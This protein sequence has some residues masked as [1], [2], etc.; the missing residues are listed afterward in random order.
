MQIAF[1]VNGSYLFLLNWHRP[2]QCL[3]NSNTSEYKKNRLF[4]RIFQLILF[5]GLLPKTLLRNFSQYLDFQFSNLDALM[6]CHLLKN[7]LWNKLYLVFL[8]FNESLLV[9]N[10]WLLLSCY[11]RVSEWTT[12]YLVWL[13][14]LLDFFQFYSYGKKK[15]TC[16][17]L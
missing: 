2:M 6:V 9:L 16:I 15:S 3:H 5:K 10:H 14:P 7:F 4:L 12:N 13:K 17:L 8:I 11:I 1:A